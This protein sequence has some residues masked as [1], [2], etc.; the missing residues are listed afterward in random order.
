MEN[1]LHKPVSS[2]RHQ[3]CCVQ[4]LKRHLC[5]KSSKGLSPV[6]LALNQLELEMV[7]DRTQMRGNFCRID[8]L[9]MSIKPGS[10]SDEMD[11]SPSNQDTT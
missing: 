1:Y 5:A 10:L 8:N 11:N 2:A 9:L 7:H 6:G 3:G 4:K